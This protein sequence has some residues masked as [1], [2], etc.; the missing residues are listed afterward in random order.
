[1]ADQL[2]S[3]LVSLDASDEWIVDMFTTVHNGDN[4]VEVERVR[5]AHPGE[6]ECIVDGRVLGALAPT[7]CQ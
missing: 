1:M 3:V 2:D 7:R 6:P 5:N 4:D